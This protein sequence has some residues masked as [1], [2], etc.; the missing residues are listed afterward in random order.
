MFRPTGDHFYTMSLVE[1]DDAI[2]SGYLN[3]EVACVAFTSQAV[4]TVPLHRLFNPTSGDHFY[5]TSDAER[6]N[7][8]ANLGYQNE[9][10]VCFLFCRRSRRRRP[11]LSPFSSFLV[12]T[13]SR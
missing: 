8:V 11:I 4:G 13:V 2:A 6:N 9:G 10:E 12:N 5:T 1:R 7:A 3:E